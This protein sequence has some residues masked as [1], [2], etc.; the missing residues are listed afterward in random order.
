MRCGGDGH[1]G[2]L[3]WLQLYYRLMRG[4]TASSIA[5][6]NANVDRAD[7]GQGGEREVQRSSTKALDARRLASD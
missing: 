5:L 1:L 6:M 3:R 7:D 4:S 2:V